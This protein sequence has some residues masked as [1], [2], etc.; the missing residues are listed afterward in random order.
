MSL[1]GKK[2]PDFTLAG[3]DGR[4]HAL[5]EY[6]GRTVVIYFYPRDNTPGC[7]KE[8]Q[9]FRD[10]QAAIQELG[11]TVLGV[12]PD[13][14]ASHAKFRDKYQLNFRLLSDV[15]HQVAEQFGAWREKTRFGKTSLGIQRS[16]YLI[17][18]AG[19]VRKVWKN[20]SVDGHD[21]QVLGAIRE[22]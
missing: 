3:S 9:A 16:T 1:E 10:R 22:L 19:T 5:G 2:A 7:T 8:A 18:A 4:D 21:E 6:A 12:S 15:D 13:D 11:A 14:P 17:D 20:V